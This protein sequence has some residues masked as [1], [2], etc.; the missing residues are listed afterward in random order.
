ILIFLYQLVNLITYLHGSNDA[1]STR[2]IFTRLRSLALSLFNNDELL[3]T[4]LSEDGMSI[5]SE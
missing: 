4:Y 5:E 2:Y 1:T 3:L